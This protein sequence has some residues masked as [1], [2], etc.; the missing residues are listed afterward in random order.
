MRSGWPQWRWIV[1]ALVL[2]VAYA[3][4]WLADAF[5]NDDPCL[6]YPVEFEQDPPPDAE[7]LNEKWPARTDCRYPIPGGGMRFVQGDATVFYSAFGFWMVTALVIIAPWR[8]WVKVN[9][10]LIALFASTAIIFA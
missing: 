2:P 4:A 9:T 3:G 1:V 5:L 8:A 6:D 10:I 7:S